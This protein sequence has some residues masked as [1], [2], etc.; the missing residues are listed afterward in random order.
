MNCALMGAQNFAD[1]ASCALYQYGTG[2]T[3]TENASC[4]NISTKVANDKVNVVCLGKNTTTTTPMSVNCG[5]G[6]LP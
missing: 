6:V 4:L 1:Q 5:N 2:T 3:P